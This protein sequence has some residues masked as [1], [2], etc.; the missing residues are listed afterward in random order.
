[1]KVKVAW[2]YYYVEDGGTRENNEE[3]SKITLLP[4]HVNSV[5]LCYQSYI[6]SVLIVERQLITMAF[7]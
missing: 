5:T 2:D 6:A 7:V 4:F 3:I 1:M